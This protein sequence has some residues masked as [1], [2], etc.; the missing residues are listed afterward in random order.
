MFGADPVWF[1]ALA[2][3]RAWT[4][5]RQAWSLNRSNMSGAALSAHLG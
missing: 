2:S 5:T 1:S 3:S 4:T